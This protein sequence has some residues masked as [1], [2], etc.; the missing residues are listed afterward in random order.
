[1]A[2]KFFH[3]Q[4]STKECAGRGDRTR[5]RLHAK[6]TR[7][8]SNYCTRLHN[9]GNSALAKLGFAMERQLLS[10]ACSK[11]N[12]GIIQHFM[13]S[14]HA[15]SRYVVLHGNRSHTRRIMLLYVLIMITF[16]RKPAYS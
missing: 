6:R 12:D 5:G 1:M 3:D 15:A 16:I 14:E 13:T 11:E 9:F 4:V 10:G 7:F 2:W 8:G